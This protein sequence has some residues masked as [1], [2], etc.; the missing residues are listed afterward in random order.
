MDVKNELV[1]LKAAEEVYKVILNPDT[2]EIDWE[3]TREVRSGA[4]TCLK[5]E[6]G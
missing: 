2:L 1:S 5:F 3:A 6:K 4:E